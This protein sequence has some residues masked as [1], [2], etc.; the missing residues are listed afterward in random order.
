M[1]SG[2]V[3][4]SSR[5]SLVVTTRDAILTSIFEGKFPDGKVPAEDVLATMFGVS[6]TTVRGALQSL[7]Q[8]GVVTRTPGR[9]TL[10]RRQMNPSMVALQRLLGFTRLIAEHGHKVTHKASWAKTATLPPTVVAGLK[11]KPKEEC[12]LFDR[13]ALA[14]GT[15]AIWATDYF[16]TRVFTRAPAAVDRQ[17][18]SPFEMGTLLIEPIDHAIVEIVPSMPSKRVQEKLG[19][20][21]TE[22]YV[23]LR[24]THFGSS[25]ASLGYSFIHVNDH[26]VRFQ[27]VRTAE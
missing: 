19:L 11:L 22:P 7:A 1:A 12:Y 13:V 8:N 3:A 20:R 14:S 17:A 15:P 27:L 16:P 5:R 10:I 18:E 23:Q 4:S 2:P 9:G 6:R 26:F 24:E 25:G 21:R